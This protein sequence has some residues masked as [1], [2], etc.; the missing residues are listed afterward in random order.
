MNKR[1]MTRSENMAR[2][3]SKGTKPEIFLRKSYGMKV[4]DIGS[5][6]KN[7][8]EVRIFIFRNTKQPYL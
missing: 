4:S 3:K 5:T 2:V 6:T 7:C 8:R 1:P